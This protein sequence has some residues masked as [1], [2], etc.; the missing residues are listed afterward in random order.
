MACNIYQGFSL[1]QRASSAAK[2]YL[3]FVF[4]LFN[5]IKTLNF[6][7]VENEM[8]PSIKSKADYSL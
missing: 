7:D 3:L 1:V 5:L 8:Y 6:K 2:G 4:N